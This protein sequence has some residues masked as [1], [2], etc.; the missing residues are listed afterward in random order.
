MAPEQA[1]AHDVDVRA[2]VYGLGALLFLL[3]TGEAPDPDPLDRLAARRDVPAPL[4]AICARAMARR[5]DD[6]YADVTQLAQEVR[7]YRSGLAVEAHAETALDSAP[8]LRPHVPDRNH[9][10]RGVSRHEGGGGGGGGEVDEKRF[11]GFDWFGGSTG[12]CSRVLGFDGF[13]AG[14]G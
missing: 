6:R 13:L 2:D 11:Y 5:A 10:G 8:P 3:V 9:P 14:G 4:R 7:R 12:A 1:S